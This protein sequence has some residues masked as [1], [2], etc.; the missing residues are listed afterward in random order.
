MK[1][2]MIEILVC[3][4]MVIGIIVLATHSVPRAPIVITEDER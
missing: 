2:F 1:R 4:A 3:V